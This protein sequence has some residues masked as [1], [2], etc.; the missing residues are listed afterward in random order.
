MDPARLLRRV[1]QD[2]RDRIAVKCEER[3]LT[4]AELGERA[5]RLANALADRGLERGDRVALLGDNCLESLEQIVGTAIGGFVRCSLHAHDAPERHRYLIEHTGAKALI[6]QSGHYQRMAG[7][8]E[9]ITGLRHVIV[10]GDADVTPGASRYD[11]VLAAASPEQPDVRLGDDDPHVIRFSAGTTGLPKGIVI[12]VRATMG[13]GNEFAMVLPSFDEEDRYLA[14]GPLTHA[15]GMFIY[16]LLAAGS[17]TIVMPGFDPGSFLELV[18]RERV[19]TTLVV[20][21][22]IQMITDHPAAGTK[23]LSSLRAVMY[24]AAPISETTLVKALGLWGN[25][26]YQLYGQSEVVPIAVLTPRHH[27]VDGPSDRNRLSS[28]GRPSPNACVRIEDENGDVLPPGQVGEIVAHAPCTM[29]GIWKDEA[30]TAARF[31][32]DGGVRTKDMG[33]LSEDGFLYLADRKEDLIISGGFNIWPAELENALA[34]HPAVQEA[35]VVGVPH[36]KWGETPH[37][38]VVVREGSEVTEQE[39]IEWTRQRVGSYKKVTAVRF[40]DALP[41]TPIGKVLRREV[42]ERFL[43]AADG[44]GR[45]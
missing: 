32:P 37:A 11:D 20:P 31:T 23:D 26:M 8:L 40:A 2:Y 7:Q 3:T 18:E 5:S 4:Y 6:I 9:E 44:L 12:S 13:M 30:G 16:P 29:S 45:A 28:A 33:Y 10:L 36:P 41:K 39:L 43:A 14:A 34:A 22:M 21:T 24:G 42:R 25:I 27:R 38:V 19:T 15:A 1:S 35:A 17:T